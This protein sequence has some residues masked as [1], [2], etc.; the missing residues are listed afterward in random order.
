M[1]VK[2]NDLHTGHQL[3]LYHP[4]P[5]VIQM[6]SLS[7]YTSREDGDDEEVIEDKTITVGHEGQRVDAM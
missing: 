1:V 6:V 7:Q 4:T 5:P 2:V 3:P